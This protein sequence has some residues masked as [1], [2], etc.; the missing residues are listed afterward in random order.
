MNAPLR[1]VG[2]VVLVLFGLLFVNL[3][4]VQGYLASSYRNNEHNGRVQLTEYQRQRGTIAVVNGR[5]QVPVAKS[6][7]TSDQLKYLRQ[8]PVDPNAYASIVGYKPVNGVATGIERAEDDFLSGTSDAL[9][10]ERLRA[11]FTGQKTTG[12]NVLLTIDQKVQEI[13]YNDLLHNGTDAKNGTVVALDPAT[14]A[15]LAMATTPSYDPN[16]IVSHNTTAA[17]KAFDALNK[18]KAKPLLNRA[19]QDAYPPGSTM[20]VIISATALTEG[21]YTPQTPI[22]AGPSYTPIAGGGFSIHNA[23]PSICPDPQITLIE[24]L[25]QSCNTGFAQL[26]VK[27]GADKIKAMAQAFG[28]EDAGLTLAGDGDRKMGV[29]PS[30]TGSMTGQNGQ[31][32]PNA[33]AQSSIGQ[34][35]VQVTPMQGA[36]IAATV[37]NGGR[38]MRPY[39]VD[40]LQ[41]PDLT[42]TDQTQPKVLRTPISGTV[43]GG[44]QQMMESVVDHGTGTKA[45]IPGYQVGGKTG[46]AQNSEDDGDHGW[47]IGFVMKDGQPIC[48]VAV[49]LQNAGSGGSSKATQIAHDVMQAAIQERGQK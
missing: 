38:Q 27:L 44:L 7:E 48:A 39:L 17:Q 25:T 26:G 6:V 3:N 5:D 46:T 43:A 33:V 1:R 41:A 10:S 47:F 12:G 37:A 15:I 21:D 9:F 34:L 19:T 2:V 22:P 35:N 31:D 16:Q 32:D 24:A 36:L 4:W 13:A 14:G 40:K 20:K 49:F 23:H 11:M 8:Y 29:V 30:H 42:T 45:K 28:F 18:D